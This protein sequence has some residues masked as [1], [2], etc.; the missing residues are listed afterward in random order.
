MTTTPLN[1]HSSHERPI[2]SKSQMGLITFCWIV[3]AILSIAIPTDSVAAEAQA[4]PGHV[5][6]VVSRLHLQPFARLP[7]SQ[8]LN[9]AI[10][11][12][13]HNRDT[14]TNLLREIYDPASPNCHR[15]L[16]PEQ[17][18]EQFGPTDQ[19][20]QS[21]I[22]FAKKHGLTVTGTHHN[23][24]LLDVSAS[25][26]TVETAFSVRLQLYHHPTENRTF[27][28]PEQEPTLDSEVPVLHIEGLDNYLVPHPT[29]LNPPPLSDIATN[30]PYAGSGLNGSFLGA[31]LRKAYLPGVLLTGTGQSVGLMEFA[32]YFTN[33]IALYA[34]SNGLAGANVTNVLIDGFSGA[35]ISNFIG[36]IEVALDIA[37]ELEFRRW[38]DRRRSRPFAY[39]H[40]RR[41]LPAQSDRHK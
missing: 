33:D 24:M 29:S 4:L 37:M 40:Q 30:Q 22:A 23:R 36:Q 14:L 12:P 2:K 6:T 5:P 15:Y 11:L 19:D 17:F 13:L 9:L 32:G 35:P 21:L 34:R 41:Q 39:V 7:A 3:A 20:Y 1:C 28:A 26:A 10:G 27:Y 25:A 38:F 18:T 16:T 31:D 8:R